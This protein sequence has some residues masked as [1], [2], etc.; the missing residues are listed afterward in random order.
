MLPFTPHIRFFITSAFLNKVTRLT[1][2]VPLNIFSVL[3][4]LLIL[5]VGVLLI[6][7]P[8]TP[9]P[10]LDDS[11]RPLAGSISEKIKV[12]INGVEQ[13]MFIKG[14]STRNPVLLYLHGG[15]ADYFLTKR[16][17]TGLD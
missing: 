10:F 4:V 13:G 8:G 2:K 11:G 5:P 12:G 17:P 6:V 3:F 14:R 1:H 7:S 9:K 15:M 16:C